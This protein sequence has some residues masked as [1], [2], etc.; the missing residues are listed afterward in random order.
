MTQTQ[1]QIRALLAPLLSPLLTPLL[2]PLR[3]LWKPAP[4][5]GSASSA[6]LSLAE[7]AALVLEQQRQAPDWTTLQRQLYLAQ[8]SAERQ[9]VTFGVPCSDNRWQRTPGG[10]T[11][12]VSPEALGIKIVQ[13]RCYSRLARTARPWDHAAQ[14]CAAQ[15]GIN[16][17]AE[18]KDWDLRCEVPQEVAA[19]S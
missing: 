14:R 9:H 3:A 15:A 19:Q 5:P 12:Q 16:L 11:L 7:A 6:S 17:H 18:D 13:G 2:S 10:I 1:P 8:W 4:T